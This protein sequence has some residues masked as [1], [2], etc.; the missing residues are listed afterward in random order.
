EKLLAPAVAYG[1]FP[2]YGERNDLVVLDPE[3]GVET[4]RFHLPRQMGEDRRHLCIADFFRGRNADA[5]GDEASWYPA[6][7]WAAGARDV[8]ATHVVTMGAVASQ[9]T[10]R[11]FKRDDYQE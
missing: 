9:W 1:F 10:E 5:L 8:L 4:A 3:S 2:C 11:L 7:A 6:A